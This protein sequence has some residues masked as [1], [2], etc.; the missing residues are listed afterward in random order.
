MLGIAGRSTQRW[1]AANRFA[2]VC[3]PHGSAS[4]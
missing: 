1:S 2:C 3:R 4:C